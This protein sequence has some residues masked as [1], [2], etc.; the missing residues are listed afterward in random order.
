[1]RGSARWMG[2]LGAAGL[3]ALLGGPG[4]SW[5]LPAGALTSEDRASALL[6]AVVGGAAWLAAGWLLVIALLDAAARLPGRAGRLAAGA[7]RVLTPALVARCLGTGA[8]LGA[9][10]GT[11]ATPPVLA[12]GTLATPPVLAAGPAGCPAGWVAAGAPAA[13]TGVPVPDL[14]RPV[15]NLDRP[16]TDLD[17]PVTAGCPAPPASPRPAGCPSPPAAP[18][19]AGAAGGYRVRPGDTLWGIAARELGGQ[20][21]AAQVAARWPRW[22]QANRFVIGPDPDL[23]LP[24]QPLRPPG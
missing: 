3:L 18:R 22:W 20:P 21:P 10:A 13:G 23:I 1:M 14:D 4:G 6:T 8:G 24:G 9:A 2:L 19:P 16:L 15:P 12:A 7:A 5:G 11:L 17:R